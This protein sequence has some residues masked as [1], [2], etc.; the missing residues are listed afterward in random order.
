MLSEALMGFVSWTPPHRE[1]PA[2]T[3]LLEAS[4]AHAVAAG[5]GTGR[6]AVSPTE[7]RRRLRPRKRGEASPQA[8]PQGPS[9]SASREGPGRTRAP[10]TR[11]FPVFYLQEIEF[12]PPHNELRRLPLDPVSLFLPLDPESTSAQRSFC[13]LPAFPLVLILLKSA[14]D[15]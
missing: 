8:T 12:K 11:C 15:F 9:P 6:H 5:V 13:F 4:I 1:G 14:L 10:D 3:W 2:T 7:T